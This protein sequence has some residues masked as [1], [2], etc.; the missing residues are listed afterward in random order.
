MVDDSQDGEAAQD[1]RLSSPTCLLSELDDPVAIGYLSKVDVAEVL[2]GITA[3]LRACHMTL[4]SGTP[5]AATLN[6][7]LDQ[8]ADLRT[9]LPQITLPPPATGDPGALLRQVRARLSDA[10]LRLDDDAEITRQ[11]R[12]IRTRLNDLEGWGQV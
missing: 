12:G 11:L 10:L 5:A 3:D 9:D 1:Q 4:D 8:L 7:I 2:A 6:A